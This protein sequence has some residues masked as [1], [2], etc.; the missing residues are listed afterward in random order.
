MIDPKHGKTIKKEEERGTNLCSHLQYRGCPLFD[1]GRSNCSLLEILMVIDRRRR[2][3]HYCMRRYPC[4]L[5]TGHSRSLV[6]P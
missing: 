4:S 3:F 2:C 5:G 1:Q 6:G